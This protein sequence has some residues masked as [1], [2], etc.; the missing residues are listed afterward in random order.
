M[1]H[2]SN[3]TVDGKVQDTRQ[4]KPAKT[5]LQVTSLTLRV[6]GLV[7]VKAY[8]DSCVMIYVVINPGC[9]KNDEFR[10]PEVT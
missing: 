10:S 9:E 1:S 6:A 3:E 4:V 7:S 2:D 8:E 5:W